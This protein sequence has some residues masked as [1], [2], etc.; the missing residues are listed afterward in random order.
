M[1]V[2]NTL[3]NSY[4][5]V[6]A[7]EVVAA[8]KTAI[9][10]INAF[11][12][13]PQ[14]EPRPRGYI[15][16][17]PVI[18]SRTAGSWSNSYAGGNTSIVS[19]Q[20]TLSTHSF[21]GAALTDAQSTQNDGSQRFLAA[22]SVEC[23]AAVARAVLDTALGIFTA[24][25]IGNV[26]G[27]S[28]VTVAAAAFDTDY[29]VDMVQ[30]A[31]AR[32]LPE[33][34]RALI[35]TD[36]YYAAL[37]KDPSVKD[38]SAFAGSDPIRGGSVPTLLGMPVYRITAMPTAIAA[39]NTVGVLVHKSCVAVGMAPIAPADPETAAMAAIITQVT[40]AE[41]GISLTYRRHYDNVLGESTINFECLHG[42]VAAQ[43]TG[44]IRLVSA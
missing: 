2:S 39:E 9:A 33:T 23:G 1:A 3:T 32:K 18:S 12:F 6:V 24:S 38:A 20:V 7:N 37:L 22:A 10:P 35:L 40:D 42:A 5:T 26:E 41:S 4:F 31:N 34:N 8:F 36:S 44:A 19:A 30:L 15:I 21:S 29:V 27:T 17:V 16:N 25:T 28:K 13:V 43:S 11:T 14:T